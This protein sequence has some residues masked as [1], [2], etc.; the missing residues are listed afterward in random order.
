MTPRIPKVKS[1]ETMDQPDPKCPSAASHD[2][3]HG[4]VGEQQLLLLAPVEKDGVYPMFIPQD[5]APKIAK[6]PYKW[7]YGR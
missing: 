6:L 5:G 3:R 7:L 2:L 1:E 4:A